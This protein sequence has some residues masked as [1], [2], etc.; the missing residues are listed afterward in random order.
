MIDAVSLEIMLYP[1][2]VGDSLTYD[3]NTLLRIMAELDPAERLEPLNRKLLSGSVRDDLIA[4]DAIDAWLRSHTGFTID[5]ARRASRSPEV[6]AEVAE[7]KTAIDTHSRVEKL[8]GYDRE[9][10]DVAYEGQETVTVTSKDGKKELVKQERRK[11]FVFI[12]RPSIVCSLN[13]VPVKLDSTTTLVSGY[14][15]EHRGEYHV[16][17]VF[18]GTE[19]GIRFMM[20]NLLPVL[21]HYIQAPSTADSKSI[22]DKVRHAAKFYFG[23]ASIDTVQME[24]GASILVVN[25]ITGETGSFVS[26]RGYRI[27]TYFGDNRLGDLSTTPETIVSTQKAHTITRQLT[28]LSHR[29]HWFFALCGSQKMARSTGEAETKAFWARTTPAFDTA[30]NAS[31]RTN[32]GKIVSTASEVKRYFWNKEPILNACERLSKTL[33]D[34]MA[35]MIVDVDVRSLSRAID[36]WR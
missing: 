3:R 19:G 22:G 21:F 31:Y 15:H 30:V 17:G 24:V 13:A 18:S 25:A 26:G 7:W 6:E 2:N 16:F 11:E 29:S 27:R 32:I 36:Y 33:G 5:D 23:I 4:V 8:A 34:D 20:D 14:T 28:Q 12:F 10:K 1:S 35:I 9:Y